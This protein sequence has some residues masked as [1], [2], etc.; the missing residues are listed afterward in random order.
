MRDPLVQA[1]REIRE[2]HKN[3]QQEVADCIGTAK[4]HYR[5]IEAG[6]RPLPDLQDGL[7]L[8]L[9]TFEDCLRATPGERKRIYDI[10]WQRVV[11]QFSHLLDPPNF[12]D[13]TES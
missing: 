8:W 10:L 13:P 3:S 6:R 11:E 9:R 1:I 5:H 2:A 7:T 12:E 4:D